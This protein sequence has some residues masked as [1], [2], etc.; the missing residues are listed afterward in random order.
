MMNKPAFVVLCRDK[1]QHVRMACQSVLDQDYP[2]KV[3][4]SNQGSV[5]RT[6]DIIHEL[7]STYRGHHEVIVSEC[8][9]TEPKGMSG[10]NAHLDWVF[11]NTDADLILINTA[12]DWAHPKRAG[13]T[14][15]AFE[16]TGADYVCTGMVFSGSEGN[17][18]NA[19]PDQAKMVSSQEILTDQVG[20]STSMAVR[21]SY[22][23]KIGTLPR[24]VQNDVYLPF[25][26]SLMNGCYYVH[27][28]LQQ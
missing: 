16:R 23:A 5:D 24:V 27:E 7:A 8:P 20:G 4:F 22:Y 9:V 11:T 28:L 15:E 26:A 1:E 10:C 25:L 19:H 12:D 13:R 2:C 3:I 18:N 14:V 6:P 17:F 21:K